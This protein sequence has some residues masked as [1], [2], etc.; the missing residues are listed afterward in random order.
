[1]TKQTELRDP[2]S[3]FNRARPY[4]M[5]FVL[6]GRDAC[7]ARTIRYWVQLR[8]EAGVNQAGDEQL[9]E[10]LRIADYMD[11]ETARVA[12]LARYGALNGRL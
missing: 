2:A 3:H 6:M 8:I 9:R 5:L 7:A 12:S 4:E 11:D 1:M 10:A